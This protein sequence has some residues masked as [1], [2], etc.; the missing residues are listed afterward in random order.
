M[1]FIVCLKLLEE[2]GVDDDVFDLVDLLV[3][4]LEG[5]G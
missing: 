1:G 2:I 4:D 3:V 5:V